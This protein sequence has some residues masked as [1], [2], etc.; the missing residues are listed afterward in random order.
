M[1]EIVLLLQAE[2]E[3]RDAYTRYDQSGRGWLLDE[4][5]E[6]IFGHLSRHPRL[7]AVYRGSIRRIP[8]R[9]FPYAVY[10]VIEGSRVIVLAFL[11]QR[12]DPERIQQRLGL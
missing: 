6:S 12:Q 7:G 11:D 2:C 9:Y 3:I 4:H 10:Y 5:L 1:S 8:L